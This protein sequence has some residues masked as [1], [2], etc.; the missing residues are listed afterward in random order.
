MARPSGKARW[1]AAYALVAIAPL[2]AT[3]ALTNLPGRTFVLELGSALGIIA[4]TLL[5]LQLMLPSRLRAV[6][7]PLGAD[8]AVRLHRRMADVLVAAIVV[9][10]ALVFADDLSRLELLD[11]VDA[12]WRARAAVVSCAALAALI[13]MALMRGRSRLSYARWRG[14]H[15]GLAALALVAAAGHTVGV[16]H[17]LTDGPLTALL[18]IVTALALGAVVELRILRPA[19]LARRP[20]VV[21]RLRAER[22]GAATLE[23]A[24]D[25]H[26]G[27]RFR[28]GQFAWLSL[29]DDPQR[30]VEH[31]FSYS[32]SAVDPA[33]PEITIKAFAG[34]TRRL[35][36]LAPGTRVRLDGPHGSFRPARRAGGFVLI[37]GGIGITPIMSL[38]RTHA[39]LGRREP[40]LLFYASTTWNDV[41]FREELDDLA[42]RLPLQVVHV[43][44]CPADRRSGADHPGRRLAGHQSR[45]VGGHRVHVRD[46]A[47]AALRDGGGVA[48]RDPRQPRRLARAVPPH[49]H[50]ARPSQ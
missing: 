37:A 33:H 6:A 13:A 24:A 44:R 49:L 38:L 16:A 8:V 3:L 41:I 15:V 5:A 27:Q 20:F 18:A 11:P 28:P 30:L 36:A 35:T 34:V 43:L 40:H 9:H 12:P 48:R 17:Y 50:R 2:I 14:W 25:E 29:A 31:P 10:V 1:V 22:G 7:G 46:R 23:L 47:D 4:L 21:R 42:D 26:P 39:D 45:H 19:R 32:S